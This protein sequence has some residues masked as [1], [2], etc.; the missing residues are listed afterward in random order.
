[1]ACLAFLKESA[2]ISWS[3]LIA[4]FHLVPPG[5]QVANPP[6]ENCGI[7]NYR[8]AD[9]YRCGG[10][11]HYVCMGCIDAYKTTYTKWRLCG[12]ATHSRY[13]KIMEALLLLLD[14]CLLLVVIFWF[15]CWVLARFSDPWSTSKAESLLFT[16]NISGQNHTSDDFQVGLLLHCLSLSSRKMD[17]RGS[18]FWCPIH[19]ERLLALC[20]FSAVWNKDRHCFLR[21]TASKKHSCGLRAS[22]AEPVTFSSPKETSETRRPWRLMVWSAK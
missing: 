22:G 14:I 20:S 6:A 17:R 9:G 8:L 21:A 2:W 1:M 3:H 15:I 16:M 7:C 5:S 11:T 19:G 18:Q 10:G 4:Q 13:F 12:G